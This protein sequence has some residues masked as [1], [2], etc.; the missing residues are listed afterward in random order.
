LATVS[1]SSSI[2]C[3]KQGSPIRRKTLYVKPFGDEFDKG[4]KTGWS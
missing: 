4:Q 2:T 3:S 1:W